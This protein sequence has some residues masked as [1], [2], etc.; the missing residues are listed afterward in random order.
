MNRRRKKSLASLFVSSPTIAETTDD[1]FG[2]K[3]FMTIDLLENH[4]VMIVAKNDCST[5]SSSTTCNKRKNATK[6]NRTRNTPPPPALEKPST[7][8][9]E[10]SD[11]ENN[12]P[13][14]KKPRVVMLKPKHNI[15]TLDICRCVFGNHKE[16]KSSCK[17]IIGFEKKLIF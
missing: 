15:K 7:P 3:Q 8:S 13:K 6:K 5:S 2:T 14:M 17:I 11:E 10:S 12:Q 9:R 4:H 1:S 16:K